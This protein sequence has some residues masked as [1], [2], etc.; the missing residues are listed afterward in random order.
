MKT[1]SDLLKRLS[2]TSKEQEALDKRWERLNG[3]IKSLHENYW[4]IDKDARTIQ[5]EHPRTKKKGPLSELLGKAIADYEERLTEEDR[6]WMIV[7]GHLDEGVQERLSTIPHEGISDEQFKEMTEGII[8]LVYALAL[9]E[10][11]LKPIQAASDAASSCLALIDMAFANGVVR[12]GPALG[13]KL[14]QCQD[15]SAHLLKEIATL[16]EAYEKLRQ[17]FDEYKKLVKL[18]KGRDETRNGP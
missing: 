12:E 15:Q 18:P 11:A 14:K 10:H 6:A 9:K 2:D 3:F 17:S 7:K 16:S 13:Q 1:M 5:V 4:E 8:A